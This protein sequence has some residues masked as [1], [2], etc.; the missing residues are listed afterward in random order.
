MKKM[1]LLFVSVLFLSACASTW[2]GGMRS[3]TACHSYRTTTD[4]RGQGTTRCFSPAYGS[5]NRICQ[6]WKT[7]TDAH[8]NEI[9]TCFSY[10]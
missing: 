3:S 5:E 2:Q 1:F 7:T 6:E 4:S 10:F 9:T 8:G